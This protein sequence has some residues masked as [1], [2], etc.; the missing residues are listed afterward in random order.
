MAL[1]KV[2][3]IVRELCRITGEP[4]FRNYDTIL[5]HVV[6]AVR[7]L[8]IYAI[9]SVKTVTLKATSLKSLKWPSDC[10]KPLIVGV[11]RNGRTCNLS[12][13]NSVHTGGCTPCS[14][15]EA[16]LE[17]N[18]ILDGYNGLILKLGEYEGFGSG[19]D[20]IGLV[21]HNKDKRE[22]YIICRTRKDDTFPF[23]YISDGVEDGIEEVPGECVITI[24]QFVLW[25]YYLIAKPTISDR[26]RIMYE[27]E[28]IKLRKLYQDNGIEEWIKAVKR[29]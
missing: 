3:Q 16:E 25:M 29:N 9:P 4:D 10:V 2:D 12:F 6:N 17:V 24:Q 22:S 20:S 14:V 11:K 18:Y 7:E 23:S 21:K 19:Y 1:I 13:D 15:S 27:R 28:F 26:A 5:S 8:Q